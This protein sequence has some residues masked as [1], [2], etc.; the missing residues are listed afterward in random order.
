MKYIS[1]KQIHESL[2][3]LKM[4]HQFFGF[5]FLAA[6]R[7][8]LPVGSVAY[9]SLDR[10]NDQ[11]LEEFYSLHPKSKQFFRPYQINY[12]RKYWVAEDYASSGLQKMNT[13]TFKEAF[14]HEMNTRKW[15]WQKNYVDFLASKLRNNMKLPTLHLA[16]WLYR[17]QQWER[18]E[19]RK[20]ILQR[21]YSDYHITREER[22]RLFSADFSTNLT[23]DESFQDLPVSVDQILSEF[24]SPEDVS[25]GEGGILTFLE[26]DGL[27]PVSP[28]SFEPARRLNIITGDNGLGKSFLLDVSWFALTGSWTGYPALPNASKSGERKG[29]IKFQIS[30]S[31]SSKAQSTQY[32]QSR[33]SWQEISNR[34]TISGL[35]VYA[36]VDGSYSIWD[37][38][39]ISAG[40]PT[41]AMLELDGKE[42]WDGTANK[43]TE[44]LIRDWVKWQDN[45]R[46]YPFDTF[47]K[48]LQCMAPPD[49]Q[50]LSPGDP[51][52]MPP[53]SR[54]FPTI[55]HPYGDVPITHES[56]GIKHIIALAYLMVW[57]WYEHEL[58]AREHGR[59]TDNQMVVLVDEM[60]VHLH[61]RWQRVILPALLEVGSILSSALELQIIIATH[62]PLVLASAEPIFDSSTDKLFHLDQ[63]TTGRVRFNELP[64]YP[65]GEIGSWLTSEIFDLKHAR[66]REAEKLISDAIKL[67]KEGRPQ[68]TEIKNLTERLSEVLPPEDSFWARWV[69]FAK[70]YGIEL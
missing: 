36:R 49:I 59:R 33:R 56:A 29:K 62:S 68:K 40:N 39:E 8:E 1:K 16:V 50:M 45:R 35:V 10:V 34:S 38:I 24:P 55:K 6:K 15:G 66:S 13:T 43:R 42:I 3:H 70:K 23:E 22:S 61:P 11:F 47:L 7:E 20:S 67:Q 14:I 31:T 18:N 57:S 17:K 27:G 54:D 44:G 63:S 48:V 52:R 60:E 30:G 4:Q 69:F 28:L 37:P 5:T 25:P 19:S 9:L 58:K 64:F 46:K 21:F 32:I 41:D 51:V 12:H 26:M 65:H 2:S 53:D